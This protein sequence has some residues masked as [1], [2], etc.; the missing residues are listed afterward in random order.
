MGNNPVKDDHSRR[1]RTNRDWWPEQL[2]IGVLHQHSPKSN[3]LGENF[4]YAAKFK[5]LE[6]EI[7]EKVR[8][9]FKKK[10]L[11]QISSCLLDV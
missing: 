11:L 10:F 1:Q 5:K 7:L 6:L 4:K 9:D 2:N 3:P 8:K